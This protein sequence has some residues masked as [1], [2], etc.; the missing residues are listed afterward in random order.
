MGSEVG[1]SGVAVG[2][3]E[4]LVSG[5]ACGA[6]RVAV[7]A[8]ALGAAGLPLTREPPHAVKPNATTSSSHHA[9]S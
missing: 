9:V 8:A 7:A 3:G 5:V 1:L 2:A 4:S 6:E